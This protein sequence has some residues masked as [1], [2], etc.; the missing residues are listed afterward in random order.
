MARPDQLGGVRAQDARPQDLAAPFGGELICEYA[1]AMNNG[2][3][4]RTLADT[5]HP[6]PAWGL[7][8]RRAADQWYVRRQTRWL[9]EWIKRIFGYEGDVVEPDPERIL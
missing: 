1:V 7:G 5:I 2:V 4:L 6:Y 3:P 9:T 8:A